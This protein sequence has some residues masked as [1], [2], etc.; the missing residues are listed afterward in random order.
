M[1]KTRSRFRDP[2]RLAPDLGG[3]GYLSAPVGGVNGKFEL[4]D[5][6]VRGV[7]KTGATEA[8]S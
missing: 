8:V 5:L 3:G 1:S 4:P 7:R 6:P 2:D